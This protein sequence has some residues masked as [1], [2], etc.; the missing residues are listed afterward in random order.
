MSDSL[1]NGTVCLG[2]DSLTL[3]TVSAWTFPQDP[4]GRCRRR[5]PLPEEGT[6]VTSLYPAVGAGWKS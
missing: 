3:W 1:C 4:P 6:A 5:G 2:L